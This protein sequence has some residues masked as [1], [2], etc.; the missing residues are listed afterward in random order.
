MAKCIQVVGQGVP[1]RL[2]DEAA[3]QIVEREH[4]G[5]YCSK[6]LWKDFYDAKTETFP[7]GR[8]RAVNGNLQTHRN[9]KRRAA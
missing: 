4:D 8:P 2:S 5:Q 9:K 7:E 3:F 1:V 6:G